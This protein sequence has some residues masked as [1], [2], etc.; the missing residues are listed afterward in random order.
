MKKFLSIIMLIAII[1][2]CCACG[3][4]EQAPTPTETTLDSSSPEAMYGHIDQNTPVNG[5]YK[6]W[7]AEGVKAMASHPDGSFEILCDIDMRGAV[8][9]PIGSASATALSLQILPISAR[10][11]TIRQAP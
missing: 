3:E 7:N 8:L 9:E 11:I 2:P 10:P 6:I 1:L 5:I 4:T